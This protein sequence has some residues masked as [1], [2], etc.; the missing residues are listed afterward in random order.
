MANLNIDLKK[1][2]INKL[3]LLPMMMKVGISALLSI[4]IIIAAYFFLFSSQIE[5][6]NGLEEKETQLKQ[7][8]ESKA[9]KAAN[10]NTLKDELEQLRKSFAVL[11]KQLPTDKEVPRLIQELNQAATNNGMSFDSLQ[12]QAPISDESID[13]LPYKISIAGNYNQL[14][15]FTRDVGSLSRIITLDDVSLQPQNNKDSNKGMRLVFT[16]TA[17]TYTAAAAI[18]SLEDDDNSDEKTKE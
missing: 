11:L 18:E 9:V 6:L 8:F 17:N 3:Y 10:Y 5:E 4:V 16:A 14:A 7:D 15:N 1:I 12:P 13:I 2:D